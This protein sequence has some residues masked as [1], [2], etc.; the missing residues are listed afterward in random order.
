MTFEML[1]VGTPLTEARVT[2]LEAELGF[3]LREDY[4]SFLLRYNGGRPNPSFFPIRGLDLNPF[5]GIHYFFGVTRPIASSNVGWMHKTLKG[6]M[7]RELLPIAGD[8]SGNIICLSRAGVNEGTVYYWDHDAEH[9]PATYGNVYFIAESFD[10]F[11]DSI[12][13]Q[14]ISAEVERALGRPIPKPN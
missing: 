11:L 12:H 14:D 7:P 4:R 8:G 2:A 10:A 3:A 1:D 13:F 5:G 9:S 6:R